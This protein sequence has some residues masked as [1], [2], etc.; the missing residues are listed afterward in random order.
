MCNILPSY[1]SWASPLCSFEKISHLFCHLVFD[2]WLKNEVEVCCMSLLSSLSLLPFSSLDPELPSLFSYVS[3][4][5]CSVPSWSLCSQVFCT[6]CPHSLQE[7]CLHRPECSSASA[8]LL[9]LICFSMLLPFM[10]LHAIWAY[11]AKLVV[12][13]ETQRRSSH[14]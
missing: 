1:P 4:I 12:R 8:H 6:K 14:R 5:H 2:E 10:S 7:V 13:E 9:Q 11:L 3:V